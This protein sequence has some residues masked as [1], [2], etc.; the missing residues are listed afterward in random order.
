MAGVGLG[1]QRLGTV[2]GLGLGLGLQRLGAIAAAA[3]LHL[4][5]LRLGRGHHRRLG[6]TVLAAGGLRARTHA[7][8]GQCGGGQQSGQ[9]VLL[10]GNSPSPK[11]GHSFEKQP[12]LLL[13]KELHLLPEKIRQETDP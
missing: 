6:A 5:H 8:G 13:K 3:E 4:G 11:K 2:L 12:S 10:H 7:H 1:L 9:D